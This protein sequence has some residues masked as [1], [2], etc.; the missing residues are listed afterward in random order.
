MSW[1]LVIIMWGGVAPTVLDMPDLPTCRS[2]AALVDRHRVM[3][4]ACTQR[5]SP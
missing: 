1:V 2:T 4:A 3:M 5:V